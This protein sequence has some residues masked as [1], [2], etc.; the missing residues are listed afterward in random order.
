M[1]KCGQ[2]TFKWCGECMVGDV[3]DENDFTSTARSRTKK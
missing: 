2:N 1:L 3:W